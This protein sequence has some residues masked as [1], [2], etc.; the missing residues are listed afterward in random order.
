MG[1][2]LKLNDSILTRSSKNKIFAHLTTARLLLF[3]FLSVI[4][5]GTLLL[6]LPFST[7][8]GKSISFIDALFT[9][10]SAT[11]VTG[12]SVVPTAGTFSAFGQ[13]VILILI[14]IGGLGFMAITSFFYSM[15]SKKL[16]LR[17]RLSM[18]EDMAQSSMQG[19]K[20]IAIKIMLLALGAEALG[21]I[22]LTIGFCIEGIPFGKSLWYG[23]FHSVS[24]FCNAGFDVVSLTGVSLVDFNNN[25]LILLTLALLIGIGGIGFIVLVDIS[26]HKIF[27]KWS[28]HTRVVVVMTLVLTFGG[29]FAFWLAER[30]NP[31]TI[32]N[33]PLLGQWI[34]SY[35]HS[36][37]CR[38]AGF[39][40]IPVD[41]M[42]NLSIP[43]SMA[44]MFIGAAPGSTGGGI[45]VTTLFILI[46]YVIATLKQKKE[47]V[48]D[49]RAIGTNTLAKAA[50]TLLLAMFILFISSVI[51]F[52][53]EN[54]R[55]SDVLLQLIFEQISAYSTC[56]LTMGITTSLSPLSKAVLIAD[57]YLGRIGAFTFFMSFAKTNRKITKIKYQEASI[58]V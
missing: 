47:Y 39:A 36:I 44:L 43:L 48:L 3:G 45:K 21:V 56:G 5:L 57:M 24:A 41:K 29:A 40:S 2:Q 16:S 1:R 32:G 22:F 10:T 20:S 58:N 15:L 25:Y 37:T 6:L 17:R 51:I 7:Q 46:A 11:C 13:V 31:D 23:I 27:K 8:K 28:L 54:H 55:G 35:F 49:K 33:M 53:A 30:T 4:I 38:T 19:L 34:N 18:S 14:Q 42:N 9:A 50:S 26:E 12:L 52:A